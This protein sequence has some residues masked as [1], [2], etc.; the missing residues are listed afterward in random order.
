MNRNADL[1]RTKLRKVRERREEFGLF[2]GGLGS[3]GVFTNAQ[4]MLT[5]YFV[6]LLRADRG[7]V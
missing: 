3:F 1:K 5:N 7:Q 2:Q 4:K 6:F